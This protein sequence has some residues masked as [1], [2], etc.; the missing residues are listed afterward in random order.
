MD[1]SSFQNIS[2]NHR[3]LEL[4]G[5]DG[6]LLTTDTGDKDEQGKSVVL[7]WAVELVSEDSS[8]YQAVFKRQLTDNVQRATKRGGGKMSGAQI[9]EDKLEILVSCT[10]GWEHLQLNGKE[11]PFTKANAREL[12]TRW[13]FIREQVDDFI[14]ERANFLDR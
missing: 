4:R 1:L 2:S 11:F 9:Q 6:E 3:R 13:P 10:K 5:P 12:Y 8:D 7:I 14:H